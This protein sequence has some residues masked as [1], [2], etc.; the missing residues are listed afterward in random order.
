MRTESARS[1]GALVGCLTAVALLLAGCGGSA[2]SLTPKKDGSPVDE[3][4]G[5]GGGRRDGSGAGG[6]GGTGGGTGAPDASGPSGLDATA[7]DRVT[8][9]N[10]PATD[11]PRPAQDSASDASASAPE[12]ASA[13]TTPSASDTANDVPD[14]VAAMLPDMAA[15]TDA[16]DDAPLIVTSDA[17]DAPAAM[18]DAAD[19]ATSDD[20]GTDAAADTAATVDAADDTPAPNLDVTADGTSDGADDASGA[21]G[22]AD[23]VVDAATDA[24]PVDSACPTGTACASGGITAGLCASEACMACVDMTDDTKCA[25]A[26]GVGNACIGGAC[27]LGCNSTPQCTGGRICTANTCV[28]CTMDNECAS[29]NLCIQGACTPG[30]CRITANCTGPNAGLI[31]AASAP[32]QC[33]TCTTDAQCQADAFYGALQMCDQGRCVAQQTCAVGQEGMTAACNSGRVCCSSKCI[34]GNCCGTGSCSVP[35]VTSGTC[36]ANQCTSCDAVGDGNYKVDPVNGDDSIATGSGLASTAANP[37]CLFKTVTRAL[38]A[39]GQSPPANTKITVI[40][41]AAT[42]TNLAAGELYPLTLPANVTLTTMTGPIRIAPPANAIAI[43]V[44]AGGGGVAPA[45]GAALTID[46]ATLSGAGV[47]FMLTSG[48]SALSNTTVSRTGDHG[49]RVNG[50]TIAIGSGVTIAE[51]GRT[52][53]RRSGLYVIVGTANVTGSLG[54]PTV[55]RENTLHGIEVA[56]IGAVNVTGAPVISS[57][58]PTG[59]GTV[60]SLGNAAANLMIAQTPGAVSIPLNTIDGLV[61]WGGLANGIRLHGGSKVTVRNSVSLANAGNGIVVLRYDDTA[62][63]NDISS[64]DLGTLTGSPGGQN[65]VQARQGSNQ[66]NRSGIC[67]QLANN[68]GAKTLDAAGNFFA[69]PSVGTPI[70]NCGTGTGALGAVN[71]GCNARSNLGN[72]TPGIGTP[73]T[74]NVMMCT[75][76]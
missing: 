22:A 49:V 21:D 29:G 59:Q 51:S 18:P 48:S 30:N 33:G 38:Q 17:A 7:A 19:T 5:S 62:A 23:A 27:K 36:R 60:L 26:Y 56:G 70:L 63:G 34:P 73:I 14:D 65:Y 35:P 1:S 76:P 4:G 54:A 2:K 8:A 68:L 74:F 72:A 42:T 20:S 53:A 3:T 57:N 44:T 37:L 46:G 15:L 41:A 32:Y 52:S 58:V 12:A 25:A 16:T 13:D 9:D 55:F 71:V 50:G 28:A 45:T 31:C 11:G 64:I 10:A 61:S 47:E 75:I 66:N 67:I 24:V 39:I 69:G 6:S 40:G 43:R